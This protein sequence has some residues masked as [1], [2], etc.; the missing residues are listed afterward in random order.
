M[1]LPTSAGGS[2][3]ENAML[4]LIFMLPLTFMLLFSEGCDRVTSNA[5]GDAP[6][7][8]VGAGVSFAAWEGRFDCIAPIQSMG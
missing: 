1:P 5:A 4:P 7:A 2:S 3:P 8:G 6:S